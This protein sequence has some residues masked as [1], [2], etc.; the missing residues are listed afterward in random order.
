MR[1]FDNDRSKTIT[2]QDLQA[3]DIFRNKYGKILIV[4]RNSNDTPNSAAFLEDGNI[5]RM[6]TNEKVTPLPNA[7]VV[8]DRSTFPSL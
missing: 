6:D 8:L 3:G 7:I 1:I 4:L 5:L 2:F